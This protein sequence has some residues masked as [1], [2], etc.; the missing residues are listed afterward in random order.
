MHLGYLILLLVE[1]IYK[2]SKKKEIPCKKHLQTNLNY[3]K[4]KLL[5]TNE[6][7]KFNLQVKC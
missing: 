6:K 7:K 1:K 4:N 5:Y 2:T 3:I